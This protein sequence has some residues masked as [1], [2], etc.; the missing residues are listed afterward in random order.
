MRSLISNNNVMRLTHVKS[1]KAL[2]RTMANDHFAMKPLRPVSPLSRFID[3]H[4]LDS[5]TGLCAT[6]V[7]LDSHVNA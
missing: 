7:A 1:P 6:C 4:E 3:R 2:N 5:Y